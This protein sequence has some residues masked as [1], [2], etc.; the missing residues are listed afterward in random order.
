M[1]LG[2][3]FYR[4]VAEALDAGEWWAILLVITGAIMVLFLLLYP[5]FFMKLK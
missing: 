4:R 3:R 2:V 5:I 1:F